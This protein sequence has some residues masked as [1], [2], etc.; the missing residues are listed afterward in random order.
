MS[1]FFTV[2]VMSSIIATRKISQKKGEKLAKTN[3]CV[4]KM[5]AKYQFKQVCGRA[6][7]ISE[8]GAEEATE[9]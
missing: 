5:L 9:S 6:G 2:R 8:P 1:S 7:Y 4:N 3:F